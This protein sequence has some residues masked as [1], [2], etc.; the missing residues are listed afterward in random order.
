MTAEA[1]SASGALV[2]YPAPM[3]SDAVTVTP[4]VE[5]DHA[6]GSRF[7][8]GATAVT[9]TASDSSGNHASCTFNVTVRD[10]QGPALVCPADVTLEA[11]SSR[12]AVVTFGLPTPVDAV[13]SSVTVSSD[14]ESGSV[15]P[16][17]QTTVK[18]TSKDAA[19]NEGSC[20]FTVTVNAQTAKTGCSSTAPTGW[21]L[22]LALAAGWRMRRRQA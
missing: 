16:V 21:A 2:K 11:T 8:I 4:F 5:A 17:G 13:T 18:L 20:E 14:H 10:T 6:S 19:E 22:I 7:P 15:F 9:L 1:T 3:V 12:G